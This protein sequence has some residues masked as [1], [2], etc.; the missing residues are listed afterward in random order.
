MKF[1]DKHPRI[2][3]EFRKENDLTLNSSK[4]RVFYIRLDVSVLSCF[5]NNAW[6]SVFL[7]GL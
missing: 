7:V 6:F 5:Y 1:S 4:L 3:R 2:I